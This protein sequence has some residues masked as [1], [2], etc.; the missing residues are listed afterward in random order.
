MS[1]VEKKGEEKKGEEKK[2]E[3]KKG[4]EKKGG[5]EKKD[6]GDKAK[7]ES[8]V[9]RTVTEKDGVVVETDITKTN[10]RATMPG[11]PNTN[12]INNIIN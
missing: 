8:K 2:G 7:P 11:N 3:E 4:E 6:G 10:I 9:E 1:Y 12:M 5:E